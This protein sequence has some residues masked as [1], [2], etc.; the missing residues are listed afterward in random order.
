[1]VSV[2]ARDAVLMFQEMLRE[3]WL[4]EMLEHRIEPQIQHYGCYIDLLGRPGRFD[5]AM[6]VIKGR[7]IEPDEA[8]LIDAFRTLQ[9]ISWEK[10]Q[11]LREF[12]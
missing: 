10:T 6:E 12:A 11:A 9:F 7:R 3:M 8:A 1:M 2:Y 4:L 5:E